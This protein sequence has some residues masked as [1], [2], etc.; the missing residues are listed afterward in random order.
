MKPNGNNSCAYRGEEGTSCAVGCLIPDEL[1][2]PSIEGHGISSLALREIL[3]H[4]GVLTPTE[5]KEGYIFCEV[6]L[7]TRQ[8]MYLLGR[9]QTIHDSSPIPDW[10]DLLVSLAEIFGL[11]FPIALTQPNP[12]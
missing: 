3:V 1:Y 6:K 11:T 2:T 12:Q 4:A 10:H 5:V 9:L 7:P 8:K